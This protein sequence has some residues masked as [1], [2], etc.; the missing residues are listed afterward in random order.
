[1]FGDG[2]NPLVIRSSGIETPQSFFVC[3]EEHNE[4]LAAT[5]RLHSAFPTVP[6]FVRAQTRKEAE[7]LKI[8]G[9]TDAVVEL[10]ELARSAPGLLRASYITNASKFDKELG[11]KEQLRRLAAVEAGITV[12]EVDCL[13]DIYTGL[14]QDANGVQVE[15]VITFLRK[16][17]SG[18]NSD[19]EIA[20][21]ETWFEA[22]GV[23]GTLSSLEFFQLYG[24]APD[25]IEAAF[26]CQR[27]FESDS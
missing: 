22:S 20:K 11:S 8:A 7:S 15:E 3:Y 23:T 4:V 1:L 10:D 5:S 2:S 26:G 13:L 6:I 25:Y 19:D 12:D 21:M 17:N 27:S 16:S 18:L 14:D 24:R 9:A